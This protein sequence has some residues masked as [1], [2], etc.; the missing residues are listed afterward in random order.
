MFFDE[1]LFPSGAWPKDLELML[2]TNPYPANSLATSSISNRKL[3]SGSKAPCKQYAFKSFFGTSK[4]TK[5]G[6]FYGRLH[7]LPPQQDILGFQRIS[8]VKFCYELQGD[9]QHYDPFQIWGYEGC[10]LP[11]GRVII[12]RWTDLSGQDDDNIQ[13][14]ID[15][16]CGP[17]I[18]WNIEESSVEPPIGPQE[19]LSFLQTLNDLGIAK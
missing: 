12:G 1:A 13:D 17:F 19:A 4:D 5:P 2:G 6:H 16:F 7:A 8:F 15:Q 10:V 3:S 18:Y 14:P 9:F 11:G